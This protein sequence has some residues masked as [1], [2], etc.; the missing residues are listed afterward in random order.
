M[1]G[2]TYSLMDVVAS[3]SGP[4]A[5]LQLGYGMGLAE[6][7]ITIVM[8]EDKN[9]MQIGG[10]GEGQH[11]L[12]AGNAGT[13]TFR[14]LKTSPANA[15]L[16]GVYNAQKQSSALWGKNL[17]TVRHTASGDAHV[18]IQAAFK[19]AADKPYQKVGNFMEWPFDCIK[20]ESDLGDYS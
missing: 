9:T 11:N 3:L 12:H 15:L 7:A 17:I 16:Q 2:G 18:G 5:N 6:E 19:K 14:F 20:I 10:D 13:I 1:K 8:L 4:G